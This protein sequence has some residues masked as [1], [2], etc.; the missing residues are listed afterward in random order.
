MLMNSATL[1]RAASISALTSVLLWIVLLLGIF[2]VG[3]LTALAP[4]LMVRLAPLIV[5]PVFVVVAAFR[6]NRSDLGPGS[7]GSGSCCWP[8]C[9]RCGRPI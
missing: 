1:R 5:I 6:S 9:C 2:I 3:A 4:D 7:C 8:A